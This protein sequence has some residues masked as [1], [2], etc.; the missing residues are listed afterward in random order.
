MKKLSWFCLLTARAPQNYTFF[1]GSFYLFNFLMS[2]SIV[3]FTLKVNEVM[4]ENLH[5]FLLFCFSLFLYLSLSNFFHQ[6]TVIVSVAIYNLLPHD[7]YLMK[8]FV[9]EGK[10]ENKTVEYFVRHPA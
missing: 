4:F 5:F 1:T 8:R 10:T 9:L 3:S 2:F 6:A 7:I